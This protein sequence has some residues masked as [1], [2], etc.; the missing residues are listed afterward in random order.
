MRIFGGD[1]YDYWNDDDNC[2]AGFTR[3]TSSRATTSTRARGLHND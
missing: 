3:P 2:G 1:A